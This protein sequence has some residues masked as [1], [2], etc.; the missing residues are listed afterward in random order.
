MRT[1]AWRYQN[2]VLSTSQT[3][4]VN[5][6]WNSLAIGDWVTSTILSLDEGP[7]CADHACAY[8]YPIP[9]SR[10]SEIV[11]RSYANRE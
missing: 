4:D 11:Q 6:L 3:F 8:N 9:N 5:P 1:V 2:Y 7:S 10:T